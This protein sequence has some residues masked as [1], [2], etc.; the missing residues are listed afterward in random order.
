MKQLDGTLVR[1]ALI[2][3]VAAGVYELFVQPGFSLQRL[4]F[5]CLIATMGLLVGRTLGKFL[6]I[7]RRR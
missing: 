5:L 1:I 2:L 6:F 4:L 3:F 7:G